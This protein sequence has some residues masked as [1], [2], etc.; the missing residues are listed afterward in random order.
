MHE[1]LAHLATL[2]KAAVARQPYRFDQVINAAYGAG[3]SRDD[4]LRAIEAAQRLGDVPGPVLAQAYA[5]IHAWYWMEARRL[6]HQGEMALQ[7]A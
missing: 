5:T 1:R 2:T 6:V 7:A 3:A 4:L